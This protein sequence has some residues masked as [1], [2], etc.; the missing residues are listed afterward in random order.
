MLNAYAATAQQACIASTA[1]DTKFTDATWSC[2]NAFNDRV[3]SKY[4]CQYNTVPCGSI[5][6]FTLPLVNSTANFNISGLAMGQT[7]F[8]RVAA[9]CGGPSFRPNVTT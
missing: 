5:N 8:Y 4:V 9:S 2:S 6:T 1:T 3:Y 7:C